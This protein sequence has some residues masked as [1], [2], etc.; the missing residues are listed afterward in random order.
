MIAYIRPILAGALFGL[1]VLL[2]I[3]GVRRVVMG[4]A[5]DAADRRRGLQ[6]IAAAL[7]ALTASAYL[8]ADASG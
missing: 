4:K 8:I 1:A 7:A 6:A 5:R 3:Y 2:V